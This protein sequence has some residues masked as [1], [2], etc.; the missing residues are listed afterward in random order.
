MTAEN[1]PPPTWVVRSRESIWLEQQHLN[2]LEKVANADIR[3][4]LEVNKYVYERRQAIGYAG[5][6][7]SQNLP[8]SVWRDEI[9][10]ASGGSLA[11]T[12]NAVERHDAQVAEQYTTW[13]QRR[14]AEA[15]YVYAAMNNTVTTAAAV[16]LIAGAIDIRL[17]QGQGV[18]LTEIQVPDLPLIGSREQLQ[19]DLAEHLSTFAPKYRHMLDGSEAALHESGPDHLGQAA[20][21]MRDLFQTLIEEL[22][23]AKVVKQQPWFK[24]NPEAPGGVSRLHR[25]RFLLIGSGEQMT[26]EQL[27]QLDLVAE[28]AKLA[29]DLAISRGHN[30]DPEL[31]EPEVR[32]AI[33]QARHWLLAVLKQ[34]FI[35]RAWQSPDNIYLA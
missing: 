8:A 25:L 29:L 6:V 5:Q 26:D 15:A 3:R 33:D 17:Q 4:G 21:S 24:V 35:R 11:G 12:V 27:S 16:T 20:H 19:R 23:D 28:A 2:D 13:G 32:L 10:S 18:P 14:D 7:L 9:M 30:H 1:E 34:Y 22:A 31:T